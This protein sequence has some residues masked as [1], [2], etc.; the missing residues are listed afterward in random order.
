MIHISNLPIFSKKRKN[1]I[2]Q[3]KY[4][5]VLTKEP[6]LG[7]PTRM[8]IFQKICLGFG[9]KIVISSE[10]LMFELKDMP[11]YMDAV[12]TIK[13]FE[14]MSKKFPEEFDWWYKAVKSQKE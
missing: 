2:R 1:L 10:L 9:W 7:L 11:G 14:K 13:W 4:Y 12:K 3:S 6:L 8:V 5:I